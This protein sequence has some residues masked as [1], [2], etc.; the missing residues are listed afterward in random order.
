MGKT[1]QELVSDIELRVTRGKPSDDLELD[2]SQIVHWLDVAANS[3]VADYLNKKLRSGKPIPPEYVEKVLAIQ[4]QQE[5]APDN[6]D[7][8]IRHYLDF[9][10]YNVMP[11]E[12]DAGITRV[13]TLSG[14]RVHALSD[15]EHLD[16]FKYLY[17]AKPSRENLM[18]YR[19]GDEIFVVGYG[20]NITSAVKLNVYYVPAIDIDSLSDTA[21][22]AITD[23][24][25][26]IIL[27][28]VEDMALRQL[29]AEFEDL[30]NDGTQA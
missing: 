18:W 27:D 20:N 7:E 10:S 15:E 21:E 12:K 25:I 4:L 6:T 9:S 22:V 2:Q 13:S 16:V 14:K 5:T 23:D 3:V 30:Q 26:A 29:G 17:F 11:L 19:E 24:L 28:V 1:K 8:G